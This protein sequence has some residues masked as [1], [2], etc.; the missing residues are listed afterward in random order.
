MN[1]LILSWRGP[2]HPLS[3]G[4]EIATLEHAKG[5]VK[6]GNKVTLF[7][8][9]FDGAKEKEVIDGIEIIRRGEEAFGVKI[10][11]FFWYLFENH[12]KFDLAIDEFHG[13]PFFT[14][15]YV[16]TKKLAFIHEVTK[17]VWWLNPW[18]KPLNLIP[19]I[20]GTVFERF[21]FTILYK[22]IPFMTV[23][24]STKSDLIDWGIPKGNVTVIYNG[25]SSSKVKV[26]KERKKTVIYL[27]ALTKDKG[28]EDTVKIFGL[29]NKKDPSFQFW[30]VGKGEAGYL[31][32]LKGKI[33]R[34]NLEKKIKFWG[35]V[36]QK[37]KFKLLS[38]A[39]VL[40][41]PSIRE[42]WGL[43]NIEANLVGT[44]VVGYDV[45]GMRDSIINRKTGLL[46]NFGDYQTLAE[47]VMR[48]CNDQKLYGNVSRNSVIWAKRFT[49]EESAAVSLKLLKRITNS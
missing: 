2:N 6:A 43:V 12:S 26:Q 30:V 49:W 46:S 22:D 14:P 1:I 11:A 16:R 13:I 21:I 7:T 44:P 42:G 39:H 24:E 4:A 9:Y 45:A 40:I 10:M 36:N 32:Y 35:Y 47:N 8:S 41:N 27:G 31:K 33:K 17:E 23:S 34:F 29:L 5:W 19:A 37:D 3:G 28:I 18:P 20:I 38:R 15:L 48:L 25:V